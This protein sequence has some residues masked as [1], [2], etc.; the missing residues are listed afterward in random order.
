MA[1][2]VTWTELAWQ[3]LERAVD[4][5]A[6]DSPTYAAGFARRVWE[7]AQSLDELSYRGR[8][9]PE[10]GD[11]DV[12]ELILASYRLLYEIRGET[13]YILGLIHGARDLTA[14]WT[15]EGESRRDDPGTP[16]SH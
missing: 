1:R 5:I 3:D 13:V 11:P 12:R 8:V 6:Q 4:T 15:R 9:V 16:R 7:R 14:L 2:S 10:L